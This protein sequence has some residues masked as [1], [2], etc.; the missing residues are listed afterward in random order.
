MIQSV[1]AGYMLQA[2]IALAF[3][4]PVTC[5]MVLNRV[6]SI[7]V[8]AVILIVVIPVIYCMFISHKNFMEMLNNGV[9]GVCMS[10]VF[11]GEIAKMLI[12]SSV[13]GVI[14]SLLYM[15]IAW[16]DSEILVSILNFDLSLFFIFLY[17]KV[18]KPIEGIVD[19]A[20]TVLR[21]W[22]GD[23]IIAVGERFWFIASIVVT[24]Y[25]FGLY[26]KMT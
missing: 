2:L 4:H 15:V 16:I 21:R 6:M 9:D 11:A 23:K 20:V 17:R 12:V 3:T 10:L 25:G 7:G 26:F 18:G 14:T 24:V 8:N 1:F 22:R 5:T 19:K 13:F